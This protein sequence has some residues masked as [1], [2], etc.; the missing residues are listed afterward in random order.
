MSEAGIKQFLDL[1]SGLPTVGPTHEIARAHHEDARVVYVDNELVAVVHTEE[2]IRG[3]PNTGAVH[4]DVLDARSVLHAPVTR[5]IL[6]FSEPIG[7]LAVALLHFVPD[8]QRP[9][10]VLEPYKTAVAEGSHLAVSHATV[11]GVPE[12]VR[13]QTLAFIDS[14]KDTQNPGFTARSRQQFREFF[15]GW[16][17]IEPGMA[18]TSEWR[19]DI[20]ED[21]SPQPENAVCLGGVARK[22]G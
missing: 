6:D 12:P 22:L 1:G 7:I 15:A 20:D 16:E 3:L 13:S 18:F 9:T 5:D 11:D 14:Y 4:A 2:I 8:S 10:T 17:L 21:A 19:T